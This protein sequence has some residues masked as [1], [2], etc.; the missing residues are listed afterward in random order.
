MMVVYRSLQVI[1]RSWVKPWMTYMNRLPKEAAA[2]FVAG[3]RHE[4]Y[5]AS[6]RT[7]VMNVSEYQDWCFANGHMFAKDKK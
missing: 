2:V 6:Q 5:N 1:D 3:V 7:A 4:R